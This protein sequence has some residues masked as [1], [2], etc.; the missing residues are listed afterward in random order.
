PGGLTSTNYA[1]TFKDGKLTITPA[2]LTITANAKSK[3]Y[4]DDLP[5]LDG[6]IVGIKNGD[7][8]TATYAAGTGGQFNA[9]SAVGVYPAAI[10]PPPVSSRKLA[11]YSVT[12]AKGQLTI[13]QATPT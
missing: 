2:P 6:T 13:L 12:L 5:S 7:P 8:I 3:V 11:D 9:L 4:G 1:I 10:V